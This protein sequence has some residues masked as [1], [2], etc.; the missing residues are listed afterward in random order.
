MPYVLD[1]DGNCHVYVDAS[2]DLDDGRRHRRQRQDLAPRRVQRRR[3]AA[4]APRRRRRV[5][6]G[7]RRGDARGRAARRRGHARRSCPR[8]A[9]RPRR[10]TRR[11]FLD[12]DPR[13]ARSSTRWTRRSSTS[14]GT[15]SG[16]SEA[17]VTATSPRADRWVR[18]VDAAAVRRQR[19]DAVRRRRR[20]RPGRR[21]R[22]LDPE[23]ARARP[24]GTARA[25]R[26]AWVV[27]GEGQVR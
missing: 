2:A 4:R 23:A 8:D 16:H 24:D 7:A 11:E 25:D 5:P 22:D 27:R 19:L 18:E 10:T 13:G 1:G 14:R 9:R 15:A 21:G 20:A 6:A 3:D 12:L 26:R 17:I